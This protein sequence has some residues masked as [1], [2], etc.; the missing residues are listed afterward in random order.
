MISKHL[1]SKSDWKKIELIA[2]N[3]KDKKIV[4]VNN[5]QGFSK[6]ISSTTSVNDFFT[7][8]ELGEIMDA[9]IK[10]GYRLEN[11]HLEEEFIRKVLDHDNWRR[12]IIVLNLTRQG[13]HNN[14]KTL[15]TSLCD[16]FSIPVIGSSTFTMNLARNKYIFSKL[17]DSTNL[18]ATQSF[19]Y[20]YGSDNSHIM[21][22]LKKLP[23]ILIKKVAGAGSLGLTENNILVTND[24]NIET[25]LENI[26]QQLKENFLI[27]EFIPGYEIEVPIIKIDRKYKILGIIGLEI[28]GNR[29][30][31]DDVLLERLS[32]D[33][34]YQF[35]DF[36]HLANL[37]KQ[38]IN[39]I[40]DEAIRVAELFEIGNYGRIDFRVDQYL[41]NSYIFDIATTPYFTEHSSFSYALTKIHN[42]EYC[43]ITS[44]L[45]GS[46]E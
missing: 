39:F 29:F 31:M 46:V 6:V 20:R 16:Y 26:S 5:T 35:Y 21:K 2:Q 18:S 3:K 42:K 8:K 7:N 40:F 37:N 27:Q 43:D 28:N 17:L 12:E 30:L 19:L 4:I 15:V 33:N 38:N 25:E 45:I 10:K 1:V 24:K 36:L 9:F 32:N 23:K 11:F 13:S 44:C 41:S 22:Q 14:K 34:N